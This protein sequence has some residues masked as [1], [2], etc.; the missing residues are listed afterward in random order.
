MDAIPALRS[1][2]VADMG[3][4]ANQLQIQIGLHSGPIVAG[5]VGIKAPRYKLFGD[6]VN[7]ASRME[8][9]SLPGR[10]QV[11]VGDAC[12]CCCVRETLSAV[13]LCA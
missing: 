3:E 8:T 9:L 10:I 12:Q 13:L 2:L 5:I 6:T 1:A 7:T 11:R 4:A